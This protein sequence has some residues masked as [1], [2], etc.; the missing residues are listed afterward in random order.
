MLYSYNRDR[1]LTLNELLTKYNES[2]RKSYELYLFNVQ[3]LISIAEYSV[4]DAGAR[5]VRL[6]PNEEDK[7]FTPKLFENECI[8]SLVKNEALQ[9]ELKKYVLSSR[10]NA[11]LVRS[12]YAD[13]SKHEDYK[14]FWLNPETTTDDT[15]AAILN[16][17]KFLINN[18][19]YSETMEDNYYWWADDESLVVGA[20]KKTIKALPNNDKFWEEFQPQAEHV[21]EFGETVLRQVFLGE[22]E[23]LRMIEPILRNW[24]IDRVA[25]VDMAMIQM[26]LCEFMYCPTVPPKVTINE[27]VELSKHYSTEDSREFINGILDKLLKKLEREGKVYKEGR[28]LME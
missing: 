21:K 5:K 28:G 20:M 9:A 23:L 14:K 12:F 27:Y 19:L 16:L 24:S 11:E 4:K 8:Q 17:Y 26:A 15:V 3:Y 13:F 2:V 7:L 25:A 22:N 10:T 18:E 6:L 1:R